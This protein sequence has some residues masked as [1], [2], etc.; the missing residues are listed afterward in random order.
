[1][2]KRQAWRA[3]VGALAGIGLIATTA[4]VVVPSTSTGAPAAA[5]TC[6]GGSAP[7]ARFADD[8]GSVHETAIACTTW[9]ALTRGVS[10]SAYAPGR[11]VTRGQAATLMARLLTRTGADLPASPPDAFPDDTGG[12]HSFATNRLAAL[13]VVSGRLDG[14]Y[15]PSAGVSRGAMASL[16][17][18]AYEARTGTTLPV[19]GDHFADDDGTVHEAAIDQAAELG[20]T[21]GTS[22]GHFDPW[23]LVSRGQ[24]ASFLARAL[25]GLDAL[26]EAGT[27]PLA[28]RAATA[29]EPVAG[30]EPLLAGSRSGPWRRS[31]PSASAP[32]TCPSASTTS[33]PSPTRTVLAATAARHPAA[34]CRRPAATTPVRTTRK[35][36]STRPTS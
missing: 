36:V 13:G 6:P 12:A 16:L 1:M 34:R 26:G 35:P 32:S 27:P 33:P 2:A 20:L 23:A 7:A 29:L 22:P 21:Q 5:S 25:T 30:C 31:A 15:A 19:G 14:R 28:L 9:W 10:P 3:K 17:V 18:A 24:A 4:G 8:N 11:D